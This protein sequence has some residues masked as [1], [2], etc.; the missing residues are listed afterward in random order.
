MTNKL[1]NKQ[2]ALLGLIIACNLVVARIFLIPIPFTKGNVNLCD[3]GIT[4]AAL[5]FGRQAGGFVGALSGLLLD[6]IS[7]YPQYMLF[8]LIAHGGEGYLIGKMAKK[9]LWLAA[10]SGIFFM[11]LVYLG[12]DSLLYTVPSGLLGLPLNLIQ[13]FIGVSVGYFLAQGLKRRLTI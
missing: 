4:L 2:V 5:L 9:S 11:V 10:F 7:G 13:G 1:V 3:A 6:L 8:S 12:A